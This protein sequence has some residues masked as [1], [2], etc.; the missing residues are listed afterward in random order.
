[1]AGTVIGREDIVMMTMYP[2]WLLRG[3][4]Y[5]KDMQLTKAVAKLPD[6]TGLMLI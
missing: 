1:M 2:V 5:N 6:I 4:L 3:P